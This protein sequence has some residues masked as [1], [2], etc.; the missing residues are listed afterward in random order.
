[1][2]CLPLSGSG[3]ASQKESEAIYHHHPELTRGGSESPLSPTQSRLNDDASI[4]QGSQ[5]MCSLFLLAFDKTKTIHSLPTTSQRH[6]TTKMI[7]RNSRLSPRSSTLERLPRLHRL[8]NRWPQ[9][10]SNVRGKTLRI[11]VLKAKVCLISC[12]AWP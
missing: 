2:A 1:M 3:S 12:W 10:T 6:L 9:K 11:Q 5:G 8:L 7:A 4:G